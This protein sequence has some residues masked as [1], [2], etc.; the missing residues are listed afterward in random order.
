MSKP[1]NADNFDTMQ[2]ALARYMRDPDQALPLPGAEPR[3]LAIYESLIFNNIESFLSGGFPVLKSLYSEADWKALV[4][5]FI[6]DHQCESP[7]F[8]EISQEFIHY[9]QQGRGSHPADPPFL[10]ELAHYEWV[11]LALDV[12]A[13]V[14]PASR[15]AGDRLMT[16]LPSVSPLAWPLTYTFPVHQ[17]GPEFQPAEPSTQPT[18][19][20]VYRNATDEVG[21]L[22]S[23][24]VTH[25]LI[26]ILAEGRVTNGEQALT[27]L[28][29]EL[30]VSEL[31]SFFD[32]GEQI[33]KKLHGLTIL[34]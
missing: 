23:N 1:L 11:E 25:R 13:E 15:I 14:L 33:L 27:N 6:R 5:A 31:D 28:A 29:S 7:Y 24:P 8:L 22:E 34:V 21:F 17:I 2:A 16:E 12:S 18:C 26:A 10:L 20:V 3:R 30:G 32:F 4:R 9:I 19:L